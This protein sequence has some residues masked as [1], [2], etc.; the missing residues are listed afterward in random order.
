[1][2][3]QVSVVIPTYN[4]SQYILATLDSVFAQTYP[5]YEIIVINDGSPD[6]TARALEPLVEQNKIQ[7]LEQE[8]QGQAAA[9][10]RGLALARGEFIAFLDD[11]DLWPPDKLEWQVE[12]LQDSDDVAVAGGSV[13]Y[14]DD[15]G[16]YVMQ[17]PLREPQVTLEHLFCGSPFVSPGQT[18][19]RAS[20][21]RQ[22]GGLNPALWG[23]DDYDLW[24]RILKHGKITISPKVSLYY[25]THAANA[26]KNSS[27]MFNNSLVLI[28]AQVADAPRA[29]RA[30]F[31]RT[32][33]R[34]LYYYAGQRM[35][36]NL[37][38]H[39][40]KPFRKATQDLVML[41]RLV[42]PALRDRRLL[43]QIVKDA[44]PTL[45]SRAFAHKRGNNT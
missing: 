10:N 33:Y 40:L 7:Y 45:F 8:N 14:I 36:Y 41:S 21:L 9:R 6:D 5:D 24:F 17:E 13:H 15:L 35:V 16:R 20:H 31:S 12:M 29:K 39:K 30:L 22:I 4:H 3:P 11:D 23:V 37:K 28:K 43:S 42:G 1:M 26:S 32:I 19:I 38:I 44:T 2:S 27:R 18:L 25:R 34:W